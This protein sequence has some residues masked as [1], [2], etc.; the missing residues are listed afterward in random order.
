MKKLELIV[1]LLFIVLVAFQGVHVFVANSV[2]AGSLSAVEIKEKI[3]I[4]EEENIELSSKILDFASFEGV[5]SKAAALGFSEPKSV[6]S[7][8]SPLQVAASNPR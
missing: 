5:A 7:L 2:S 6:I 4:L 8:Y 1:L 3:Q